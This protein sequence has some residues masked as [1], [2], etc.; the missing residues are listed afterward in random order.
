MKTPP[1]PHFTPLNLTKSFNAMRHKLAAGLAVSAADGDWSIKLKGLQSCRGIP[2][3]FGDQSGPD[4]LFLRPGGDPV[5][6][7]LPSKVTYVI[8]VQA[9][10]DRQPNIRGFGEIGPATLGIDGNDL[11][12][13]VSTY[14]LQ[15]ADGSEVDIPVSRR[16]GIQ[17][18][19]I[20]WA[21]S[22][23]AAVPARAPSVNATH[24]EDIAFERVSSLDY[25]IAEQRT[26]SGRL[27][28][29]ENL[30]LY[31]LP[32]PHPDR[33]TASLRLRAE[34]E[35]SLIYAIS[36]T[37]LGEHPLRLQGRRKLRMSLPDGVNVNALG[38][39]DVDDRGDQIGID[40]GT[41][42]S[43]RA[44]LEYSRQNWLSDLPAWPSRR[45]R[46]DD[47]QSA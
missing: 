12:Q 28:D 35:E 10:A 9:V 24:A 14:S 4:V 37:A 29:V 40:L 16:F 22:P 39:L 45:Y 11:G 38:E 27:I 6:V 25:G 46:D 21:A 34:N 42:I 47:L 20:S 43:A 32:N 1:S 17:Q 7:L 3:I 15:Y 2:F 23:F 30:W 19:H 31:A 26:S 5:T 44:V 13:L 41:V 18:R 36:T 8:F 33:E